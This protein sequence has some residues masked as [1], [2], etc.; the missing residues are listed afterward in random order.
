MKFG[1]VEFKKEIQL[2]LP[3]FSFHQ[4]GNRQPEPLLEIITAGTVW[5]V[6]EWKGIHIPKKTKTSDCLKEYSQLS[7]S[8]VRFIESQPEIKFGNGEIRSMILSCFVRN[9]RKPFLTGDNSKIVSA[10]WISSFWL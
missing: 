6:P 5:N 9:G 10:I 3:A 4:D 7:S 1:K 2:N 8:T